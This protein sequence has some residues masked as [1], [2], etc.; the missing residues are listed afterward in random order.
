[1]NTS[2]QPLVSVIT[3]VYNEADHLAECIESVLAQSY[4][5]WDYTIVNNCSTDGSLGIARRYAAQD[6]RI[7]VHD[8][9][10]FLAALPNHNFALRQISA[11]SKYCKVVLGDDWI[12]PECLEKMVAVAEEHPS[13]G[14]VSGYAWREHGSNGRVCRIPA[15]WSPAAKFAAGTSSHVYMSSV[16][17][18]PS[19]IEL[20]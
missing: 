2:F 4:Q 13:V 5:N 3:P 9:Q 19:F 10:E 16:L 11:S 18:V 8:N 6:R 14:I 1:M 7:R 15:P 17:R 12:F 20:I